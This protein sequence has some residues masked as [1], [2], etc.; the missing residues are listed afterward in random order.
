MARKQTRNAQGVGTFRQRKDGTWE[1]RYTVGRDPG[2]GKQI[3]KSIYGKTQREV[4]QKL[5]TIAKDIDDGDYLSPSRMTVKEWMTEWLDAYT[6]NVK[7]YTLRNYQSQV[8]NHIVPYIGS[9][10]IQ[11]LTPECIQRMYNRL[12]KEE[13]L[14]PKTIRNIHGIL[15]TALDVLVDNRTIRV[16]PST[17]CRKHLPK[18]EKREMTYIADDDL[19]TFMGTISGSTYENLFL[20]D[21]FTGLRQGELLGLRWSDIDFQKGSITVSKQ[22]YMPEKGGEYSLQPLKNRKSRTIWPAPFVFTLLRKERTKQLSNRMRAGELWDEAGIPDLVFTNE[23]GRFLSHKTVYHHFKK[24]VEASGIPT[25]RF[26]DMRHSYAVT[27]L[28][29]GDNIKEIQEALGHATAAFTLSTYSHVTEASK[30]ESA[31]RME[32][33]IRSIQAAT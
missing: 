25:V 2:T 14:S 8:K 7:P 18:V 29:A 30:K 24:A 19:K 4:R 10:K 6:A 31:A 22:L 17:V 21:L 28:K 11:E 27:S 26:H 20:I 16:N 13:N 1:A 9:V 5:I 23:F 12:R 3:Q 15:H 33:Y 32:E